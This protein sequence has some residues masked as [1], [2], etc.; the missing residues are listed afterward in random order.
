MP[1][2]YTTAQIEFLRDGIM[3]TNARE[4][5]TQFNEYFG[6]NKTEKAINSAL[7]N[8]KIRC[9]RKGSDR[10]V[11]K[12]RRL[13][14]EEQEAFIRREYPQRSRA[15]LTE[16]FNVWF[17]T[18]IKED[19]IKCFVANHGVQSGRSGQF[20]KGSLPW[21]TGTKGKRLTTRNSGSFRKGSVPPNRK[22]I[23]TERICKKDGFVLIK[24]AE[25]DPNTGFPTRYKH[26]HRHVWEQKNG[27]VPD[28]M[29]IAFRDGNKLNCDPENLMLISRLELLLLNKHG[30]HEMPDELKPSVLGLAKLKASVYEKLKRR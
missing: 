24:V 23:G 30:Y 27:P 26:K 5:T 11:T 22:P 15:E 28:G 4:L 29:I 19:Q 25:T 10:I 18:Q 7:K 3:V 1:N 13:F 6:L 12:S 2:K 17:G 14:T 16:V 8:H 20:K 9:G 21:N